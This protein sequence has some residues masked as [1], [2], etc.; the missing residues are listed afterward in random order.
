MS[1]T[2]TTTN[3]SWQLH[4]TPRLSLSAQGASAFAYFDGQ[5]MQRD[6][7]ATRASMRTE[8]AWE[9]R[10]V[11]VFRFSLQGAAMARGGITTFESRLNVSARIR[12]GGAWLGAGRSPLGD[13]TPVVG[14]WQAIGGA[15]FTLT[16]EPEQMTAKR[17]EMRRRDVYA[18]DSIPPTDTF[19]R[20]RYTQRFIGTETTTE[21]VTFHRSHPGLELRG[22][23]AKGRWA[24]S[25]SAMRRMRNDSVPATSAEMTI[26]AAVTQTVGFVASG[27]TTS[28]LGAREGEPL[29]FASL[30]VRLWSVS[31]RRPTPAAVRPLATAFALSRSGDSTYRVTLRI[32]G[33]RTAEISGDF[34]QWTPVTL[35]ETSAGTWEATLAIAPGTH[36]VNVRINGD[37]WTEPPGLPAVNDEFAGRVGILIVP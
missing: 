34:N 25:A 6:G 35:R 5:L 26:T 30:G 9:S 37:R 18:L 17:D 20:W 23:W 33:A 16:Y 14:V 21:R 12:N 22:D 2:A 32:P 13:L 8:G 4:A 15:L 28:G 11:G 1:G 19:P 31:Q 27:G 36:R 10:P 29:R 24:V 3:G 7:F